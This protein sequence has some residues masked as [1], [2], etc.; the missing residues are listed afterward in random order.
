MR[1]S[2]KDSFFELTK[3]SQGVDRLAFAPQFQRYRRV[4]GPGNAQRGSADNR[5]PHIYINP[6]KAGDKA[7]PAARMLDNDD[8]PIAAIGPRKRH[9]SACRGHDLS[10]GS[11]SKG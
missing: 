4:F 5:L 2:P 3:K 1:A 11:R 7:R 9:S 10:I 6:R 8:S